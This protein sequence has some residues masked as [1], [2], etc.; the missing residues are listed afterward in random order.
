MKLLQFMEIYGAQASIVSKLR[1]DGLLRTSKR[2]DICAEMMHDQVSATTKD[3]IVFFCSKRSC[4]KSKTVRIDSFFAGSKLSLCECLL[5]LH[6][7]SKGYCEKLIIDDFNFSNKT[8]VDWARF[9]RDL[10]VYHFETDD[11]LIGG[12]GSIVEIDETMAVRRK[13]NRGRMLSAGWLF[14]GIERRD[15]NQFRCFVRMVYNRSEG[16]LTQLIHEHVAAGTHIMTDGWAAYRNLSTQGY[17]HSVVIHEDNFVSPI[18]ANVHTQR[19]ESTWSS[20][21]RFIRAHGTHKGDYYLEYIC[22]YI[23]RRKHPDVF[24]AL[25]E[26]IKRKYIF[27]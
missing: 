2:C 18:D 21:K 8:V 17:T 10:A 16:H 24:H 6:L 25:M 9:C 13:N 15:D 27:N 23:F 3:G 11:S 22:E 19:I 4:R 5:F 12:P 1:E 26:T 14:G 7:W 20:L